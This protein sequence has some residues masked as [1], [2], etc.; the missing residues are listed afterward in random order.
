MDAIVAWKSSSGELLE[1]LSFLVLALNKFYYVFRV[2][3]EGLREFRSIL[4]VFGI[5]GKFLKG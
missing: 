2:D 4:N 3:L 5:Y 1:C